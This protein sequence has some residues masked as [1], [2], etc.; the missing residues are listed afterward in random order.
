MIRKLL[1]GLL[2]LVCVS[3]VCAQGGMNMGRQQ[4]KPIEQ[5]TMAEL[6]AATQQIENAAAQLESVTK[7]TMALIDGILADLRGKRAVLIEDN[8]KLM[9]QF[10]GQKDSLAKAIRKLLEKQ[11]KE[12][13]AK[14]KKGAKGG[15]GKR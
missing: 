8:N 7:S 1:I 5:M 2:C 15:N 10:R 6:Q 14:D 11:A 3:M 12:K 9:M 13:E 4:P